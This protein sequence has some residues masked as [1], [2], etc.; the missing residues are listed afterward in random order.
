MPPSTQPESGDLAISIQ[1]DRNGRPKHAK[2]EPRGKHIQAVQPGH[3][4]LPCDAVE[5]SKNDN[6]ADPISGEGAHVRIL[7]AIQGLR[8]TAQSHAIVISS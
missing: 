4:F 8:V 1:V 6:D 2:D 5:C 3:F 7:A